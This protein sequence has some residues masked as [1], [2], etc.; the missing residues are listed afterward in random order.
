VQ[1]WG[2]LTVFKI[3]NATNWTGQGEEAYMTKIFE[4]RSATETVIDYTKSE[5]SFPWG[6]TMTLTMEAGFRY[7]IIKYQ[8]NVN[9][10]Y[11]VTP[12][13]E[14]SQ[15]NITNNGGQG[16]K[17][18]T[19]YLGTSSYIPQ[20]PSVVEVMSETKAGVAFRGTRMSISDDG[21]LSADIPT[22]TELLTS[23]NASHFT[24]NTQT[25]K[26]DINTNLAELK[27]PK[28]DTGKGWTGATYSGTTGIVTFASG[29]ALGF[30]TG[31]IR[32]GKGDKGNGWT[33]ATY[34]GITGIVTFASNDAL[35]F[36]TGD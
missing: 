22:T 7:F 34:S 10:N 29:D 8:W 3:A 32:G 16:F 9:D 14:D 27:G 6:T 4:W 31:D 19:S 13:S 11:Y 21:A 1:K 17:M 15:M 30:N 18:I 23:M 12:A 26:I 24:N 25:G 28:G 35:G 20:T 36:N 2:K 5:A 33:G